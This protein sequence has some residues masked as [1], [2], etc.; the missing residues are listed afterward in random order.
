MR[1]SSG[2][3]S[4]GLWPP[5]LLLE[6]LNLLNLHSIKL[7]ISNDD[8]HV[9]N[10]RYRFW[11][12]KLALMIPF[13]KNYSCYREMRIAPINSLSCKPFAFEIDTLYV[14]DFYHWSGIT[15]ESRFFFSRCLYW[16]ASYMQSKQSK[17]RKDLS[18]I[19]KT[20]NMQN[21]Y[22]DIDMMFF[23]IY[24]TWRNFIWGIEEYYQSLFFIFIQVL[25]D[26][27]E[28]PPP[29]LNFNLI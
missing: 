14:A 20:I 3:L 26:R 13:D 22:V 9:S 8:L 28:R 18:L 5:P 7:R 16:L 27:K 17:Q 29:P 2:G 4:W 23:I 1:R 24:F 15:C 11:G 19:P 12:E 21:H 10:L 25:E 6:N